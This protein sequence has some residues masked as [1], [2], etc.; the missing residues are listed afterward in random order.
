MQCRASGP[1]MLCPRR[2]T[3]RQQQSKETPSAARRDGTQPQPQL[4]PAQAR[5]RDPGARMHGTRRNAIVT[6]SRLLPSTQA[7]AGLKVTSRPC[8]CTS[9]ASP[10]KWRPP[11]TTRSVARAA[12]PCA[13]GYFPGVVIAILPPARCLATTRPAACAP[14]S[15]RH[16]AGSGSASAQTRT[17]RLT[18]G[19]AAWTRQSASRACSDDGPGRRRAQAPTKAQMETFLAGAPSASTSPAPATNLCSSTRASRPAS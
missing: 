9:I 6:A 17:R 3:E 2:G 5:A 8:A 19:A 4:L 16:S 11:Q 15:T 13:R 1:T 18:A 14:H 10:A 12:A 7:T